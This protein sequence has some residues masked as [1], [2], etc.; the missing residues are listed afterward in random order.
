MLSWPHCEID[1]TVRP[2]SMVGVDL[3]VSWAS[4]GHAITPI[5]TE[6]GLATIPV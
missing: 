4:N 3:R 2:D 1:M 6:T 5:A